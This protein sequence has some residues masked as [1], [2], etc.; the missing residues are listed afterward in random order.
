MIVGSISL[1]DLRR[2]ESGAH[3]PRMNQKNQVK[4]RL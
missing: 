4:I 3:F 2:C 1:I